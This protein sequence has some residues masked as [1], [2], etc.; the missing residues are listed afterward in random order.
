MYMSHELLLH[1]TRSVGDMIKFGRSS[2]TYI[3]GGPSEM[4]PAEG[5]TRAQRTQLA[6]VEVPDL[7]VLPL[8]TAAVCHACTPGKCIPGASYNCKV[9]W[10]ARGP[11][12][13]VLGHWLRL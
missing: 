4:M 12:S 13:P 9:A 8:I 1:C 6:A 2:R 7:L 11:D 5:L 10:D 3:L